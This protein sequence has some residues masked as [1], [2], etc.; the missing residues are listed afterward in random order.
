M[1]IVFFFPASLTIVTEKMTHIIKAELGDRAILTCHATGRQ[2]IIFTWI[3]DG[4]LLANSSTVKVLENTVVVSR[5]T[6]KDYG[7]Y[8]CNVSSGGKSKSVI[9]ELERF[10]EVAVSNRCYSSVSNH[11]KDALRVVDSA[12]IFFDDFCNHVLRYFYQNIS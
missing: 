3:K 1:V 5:V 6:A 2:P 12:T 7:T 10:K 8:L 11:G 4:F 9:M